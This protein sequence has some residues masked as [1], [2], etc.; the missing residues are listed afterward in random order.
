MPR[1]RN[2]PKGKA[3]P[4]LR[5]LVEKPI[6]LNIAAERNANE[7]AITMPL[8]PSQAPPKAANIASPSPREVLVVSNFA[9]NFINLRIKS[10][11]IVANNS[12][13]MIKNGSCL[14]IKNPEYVLNANPNK[15]PIRHNL[16]GRTML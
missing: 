12:S 11:A 16:L 2:G 1:A 6:K 5:F 15:I 8:T 9:I 7:I 3:C 13:A 14:I 10:G 4:G